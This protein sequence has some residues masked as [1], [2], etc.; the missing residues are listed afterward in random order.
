MKTSLEQLK[1]IN[2]HLKHAVEQV[3]EGILIIEVDASSRLGPRIM[4]A[5]RAAGVLSGYDQK[6]LINQPIGLLYDPDFLQHLIVRLPAVAESGTLFDT[7]KMLVKNG[8]KKELFRWTISGVRDGK[9]R[10]I[11]YTMTLR[12]VAI[13]YAGEAYAKGEL[14]QNESKAPAS[15]E[16]IDQE[17][18]ESLEKSR[19]ES[20]ALLAGGIAHDFNNVLTSIV[21]NLSLAVME[22]PADC[23]A[24]SHLA[25]VSAAAREA[26]SLAQQILDFTK[27]RQ[28]MIQVVG[29]GRELRGVTKMAL[30][31]MQVK[32]EPVV[33]EGLWGVEV[34]LRQIRQVM[35][36]LLINACQAMKDGGT[37]Q[38]SVENTVLT[39]ESPVG[40][41]PGQ[42]V[43]LRVR[44]RGCGISKEN[45]SSIFEPYYTT[46]KNGNGIGLATCK[47]IIQRHNGAITV[48][49]KPK[50]GTE[51]CVF[52]PKASV[53]L[54]SAPQ[55]N[56]AN[57]AVIQCVNSTREASNGTTLLGQH[58]AEPGASITIPVR[59]G[60]IAGAGEILVVDDQDG[61]RHAA[62]RILQKI[63]YTPTGAA[64][65]QE[66]VSSY[67]QRAGSVLPYRAVLLDMT[68]PGGMN[69]KEVKDEI[70]K[71]DPGA[72]V[73]ATSGWFDED[74]ES[75]FR[76]EGYAGILPKPY[77]AE[78]L[79]QK[80]DEALRSA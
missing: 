28:P 39:A 61:V 27:G 17:I 54:G 77:S 58:V 29:L 10:T 55:A 48:H 74:A 1:S 23:E 12:P 14:P 56:G 20:L 37:I 51:F 53:E 11:N 64:D 80:L 25:E 24:R 9:G 73:I 75:K 41:P 33:E 57:S 4:Y 68:L 32:C 26:Q 59:G 69:G 71:L 42:Y 22:T 13:A 79:S 67:R 72:T 60:M 43:M 16:T 65:G 30:M 8:G 45:I 31:G 46:K 78:D 62:E 19:V 52:L 76:D 47:A 6:G 66:A 36:N 18:E 5:N 70:M 34:D 21:S 44:D 50:A 2:H 7:E 3:G 38:A 15:R 63:G 35:H 40:L 49:S